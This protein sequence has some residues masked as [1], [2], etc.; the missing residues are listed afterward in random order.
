MAKTFIQGYSGPYPSPRHDG[1]KQSEWEISEFTCSL[2]TYKEHINNDVMN[3]LLI[4]WINNG[5]FN[6]VEFDTN[7]LKT[8]KSKIK[9][10]KGG[11]IGSI[12]YPHYEKYLKNKRENIRC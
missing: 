8:E 4:D 10:L 3:M 12:L 6:E 7:I 2:G 9:I 1:C 5:T 11:N